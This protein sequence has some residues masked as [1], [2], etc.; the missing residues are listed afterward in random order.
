[1]LH[2]PGAARQGAKSMLTLEKAEELMRPVEAT[3][4]ISTL[5]ALQA[6]ES[7]SSADLGREVS[8]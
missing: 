1:M 5:P 2:F 3:N 7:S 4:S 6:E 8:Y